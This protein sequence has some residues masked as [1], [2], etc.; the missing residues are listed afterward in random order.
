MREM[1]DLSPPEKFADTSMG[2]VEDAAM[3]ADDISETGV[4]KNGP[5]TFFCW[6]YLFCWDCFTLGRVLTSSL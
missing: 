6:D 5:S 3:L 4:K 2:S 1:R